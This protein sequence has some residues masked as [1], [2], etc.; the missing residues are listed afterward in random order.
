MYRL[1]EFHSST[2][3]SVV[4][5]HVF[6][7]Q[8]DCMPHKWAICLNYA[9]LEV[10][11]ILRNQ[12]VFNVAIISLIQLKEANALSAQRTLIATWT[13]RPASHLIS[14]KK[15]EAVSQ[16]TNLCAQI[17]SALRQLT[18]VFAITKATKLDQLSKPIS[19]IMILYF[20]LQTRSL[21]KLSAMSST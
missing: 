1:K 18:K 8:M 3:L 13:T 12:I 2:L 9:R 14:S 20:S 17:C 11:Q 10:N 6:L 5:L 16:S 4:L 7:F 15:K 21:C 19:W